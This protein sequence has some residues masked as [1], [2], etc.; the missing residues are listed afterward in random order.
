MVDPAGKWHD[1]KGESHP[2]W[3]HFNRDVVG[4][5]GTKDIDYEPARG[6]VAVFDVEGRTA[7]D[8]FKDAGWIRVVPGHGIEIDGLHEGN[9]ALVKRVL[10]DVLRDAE[11]GRLGR[12]VY[13]D[14]GDC[15]IPVSVTHTGRPDFSGLDAALRVRRGRYK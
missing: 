1:T 15:T 2:D 14:T 11:H 6:D 5:V 4:F 8:Y 13:V 10:R 3:A 7:L 12:A 9:L